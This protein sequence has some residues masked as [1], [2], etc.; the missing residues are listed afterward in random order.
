MAFGWQNGCLSKM[1]V[2]GKELKLFT[3]S[4]KNIKQE[5]AGL[6]HKLTYHD[7]PG[8]YLCLL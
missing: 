8:H 5:V 4:N 2:S 1:R 6:K 7:H 3:G